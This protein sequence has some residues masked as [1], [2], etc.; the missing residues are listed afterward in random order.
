GCTTAS[1]TPTVVNIIGLPDDVFVFAGADQELCASTRTRLEAATITEGTAVW[2]SPTGATIL[3]INDPN[4]EVI[5]LVEGEN[6]FVWTVATGLC[7][8]A[9]VDTVRITLTNPSEDVAIA[10]ADLNIC[11]QTSVQ[12]QAVPPSTA[13]G[14]WTQPNSQVAAGVKIVDPNSPQT[15]VTGLA[16]DRNYIFTWSLSTADCPQFQSDDVAVSVSARPLSNAYIEQETIYTCGD[17]E[18]MI[19]ANPPQTATGQWITDGAATIVEAGSPSSVVFDLPMGTSRFIW[20]L[21]SGACEQY[22]SDTLLVITEPE[23][24][25]FG[26]TRNIDFNAAP[27]TIDVV[28]N[29]DTTG[30][31][32]FTIRITNFPDHGQVIENGDGTITYQADQNYSGMD[33]L[34]YEICN[35]NCPDQCSEATVQLSIS[36]VDFAND[37]FVFN[38]ITPNGDGSNDALFISCAS[39]FPNNELKVFNRWGDKVYEAS[40]YLNDWEATYKGEPLP[41]GTYYYLFKRD[42]NFDA[43]EQGYIT[44]FR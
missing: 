1:S 8:T 44:I 43:T 17:E 38:I 40:G 34:V 21:S 18:I 5:D 7:S 41:A 32:A 23:P 24:L 28:A 12:L 29:D 22:S 10:G 39:M 36:G 35:A 31:Q 16:E 26:E 6:I 33:S 9:A 2:T 3:D 15:Q 4:T 13:T 25:A 11:G 14:Q 30:I 20:Q 19:Q 42:A 27:T 37:C